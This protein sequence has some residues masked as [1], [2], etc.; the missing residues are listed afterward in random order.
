[1]ICSNC[2]KEVAYWH[3]QPKVNEKEVNIALCDGCYRELRMYGN[4]RKGT[5]IHDYKPRLKD[6][7]LQKL[8]NRP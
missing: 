1:M 7:D 6:E 5:P 2:K 8:L 4:I 3:A